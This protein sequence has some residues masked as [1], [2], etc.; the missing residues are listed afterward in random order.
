[1]ADFGLARRVGGEFV[2]DKFSGNMSLDTCL[3]PKV[4]SLWYRPP[5]LLFGSEHYDQGVDNWGAGCAFGEFLRGKPLMDG[6]NELEQL[7][8]MVSSAVLLFCFW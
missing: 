4:A 6:K 3:T 1:M 5:E 2:G 8:K 7:Q